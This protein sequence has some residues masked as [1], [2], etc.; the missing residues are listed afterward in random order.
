MRAAC[1][2]V[3]VCAQTV[4]MSNP[5]FVRGSD[6]VRIADRAGVQASDATWDL[7]DVIYAADVEVF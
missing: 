1:A 7:A 3:D 6:R 5:S 4:G 2:L